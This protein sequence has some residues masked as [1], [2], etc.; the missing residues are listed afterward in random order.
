MV[1][2]MSNIAMTQELFEAKKLTSAILIGRHGPSAQERYISLT[3]GRADKAVD[4]LLIIGTKGGGKTYIAVYEA[5]LSIVKLKHHRLRMCIVRRVHSSFIDIKDKIIEILENVFGYVN[6]VDF[7]FL[8]SPQ[9]HKFIFKNPKTGKLN[10]SELLMRAVPDIKAYN[11]LIHGIE[12]QKFIFDEFSLWETMEVW[13]MCMTCLRYTVK[14]K[15]L[16]VNEVPLLMRAT[17]NPWEVGLESV[18]KY[19]LPEDEKS[20]NKI[21]E[22]KIIIQGKEQVKTKMTLFSSWIENYHLKEDWLSTMVTSLKDDRPKFNAFL[23]GT[24]DFSDASFFGDVWEYRKVVYKSFN[25][26]RAWAKT[27]RMCYDDG[28]ASPFAVLWCFKSDGSP[29]IDWNGE[30]RIVP[31]N[32]IFFFHE[33]LGCQEGDETQGLNWTHPEIAKKIKEINDYTIPT[34]IGNK[35]QCGTADSAIFI[36][37][38]GGKTGTVA[39]I[40]EKFSFYWKKSRKFNGSRRHD[41]Q[42]F[43]AGLQA[44]KNQSEDYPHIY[45]NEDCSYLI[46]QLPRLKRS[47]T[48][49]EDVDN[50]GDKKIDHLFDAGKGEVSMIVD[51]RIVENY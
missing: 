33:F 34:K 27:A 11:S 3:S 30:T 46:S 49:P 32:S 44:T 42:L 14:D 12:F 19:F 15:S 18:W 38:R 8:A 17:S 47:K 36:N 4:E 9:D 31:K 43:R 13:K 22:R 16:D 26:P 2:L 7:V 24:P 48:D 5:L 45:I 25:V 39:K 29:F 51:H 37:D 6:K 40:F 1:T 23:K 21:Y 35:A 28:T 41:A 20:Y 10:G 50:S